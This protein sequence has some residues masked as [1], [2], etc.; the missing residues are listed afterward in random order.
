M[1]LVAGWCGVACSEYRSRVEG[2]FGGY[3]LRALRF[4]VVSGFVGQLHRVSGGGR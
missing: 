4:W 3:V 1:G 2:L